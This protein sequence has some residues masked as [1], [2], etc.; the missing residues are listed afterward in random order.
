MS[1]CPAQRK[2]NG[3]VA[4][5]RQMCARLVA[6]TGVLAGILTGYLIVLFA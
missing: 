5:S 2:A 1:K 4:D 6:L 3:I